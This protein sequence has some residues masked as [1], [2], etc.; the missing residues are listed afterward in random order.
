MGFV[1]AARTLGV[2][3]A[4]SVGM[5]SNAGTSAKVSGSSTGTS[6]RKPGS[7]RL[8]ATAAAMP[9]Q[10]PLMRSYSPSRRTRRTMPVLVEPS[11]RDGEAG[12]D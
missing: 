9:R 8:N 3:Q 4:A 5:K 11:A 6:Y 12:I 10:R 1:V 7:S 2:M